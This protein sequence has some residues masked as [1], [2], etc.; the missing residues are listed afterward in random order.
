MSFAAAAAA[1]AF[2]FAAAS[3][4]AALALLAFSASC[5][6]AVAWS[7]APFSAVEAASAVACA[8]AICERALAASSSAAADWAAAASARLRC[9]AAS[10]SAAFAALQM[11]NKGVDTRHPPAQRRARAPRQHCKA[12][13]TA[14]LG[15]MQNVQKKGALVR[16]G[17]LGVCVRHL[18]PSGLEVPLQGGRSVRG[19]KCPAEKRSG[20]LRGERRERERGRQRGD[21]WELWR[22]LLKQYSGRFLW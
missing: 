15:A 14:L 11:H 6:A 22:C 8:A 4:V 16:G 18:G 17:G 3:S 7:T 9:A 5:F 10:A 21:A 2:S 13:L 1:A 12:A 20:G 19:L